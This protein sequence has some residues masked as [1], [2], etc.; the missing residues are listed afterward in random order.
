VQINLDGD[1]SHAETFFFRVYGVGLLA[2]E[3]K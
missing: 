3:A 1:S 2:E